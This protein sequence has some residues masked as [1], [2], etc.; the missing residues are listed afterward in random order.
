MYIYINKENVILYE[1]IIKKYEKNK[2]KKIKIKKNELYIKR[3]K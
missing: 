3:K 2:N 1:N